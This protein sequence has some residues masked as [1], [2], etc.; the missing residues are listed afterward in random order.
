[1]KIRARIAA[2]SLVIFA[3][4]GLATV[5]HADTI[6]RGFKAKGPLQPGWV[7]ALDK[8]SANTVVAAPASDPGRI[9]GVVIDP[10][11]APVTV[12]QQGQQMY[13][14]NSGAYQTLVTLSG[15]IITP[16][17]YIS[18]SSTDGIG[19]RANQHQGFVLGQAL[20]KFDGKNG[21]ITTGADGLAIG[22][23][24]VSI[25]PGKN[26]LVKNDTAIPSFL[27]KIA[28]GVAGTEKDLT[29]ARIWAA[30]AI[31]IVSVIIAFGVLWIGIRSGMVAIGRNPLSRHSIMQ[32]LLQVIV[33]A[34]L[35]LIT[36]LVG[37]YLLL[38]L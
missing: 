1:M 24:A 11:Q 14:A 21:V 20:E 36:G 32:S 7:V 16:G 26:P 25:I 28:Q 37:V 5:T 6:V 38:K 17:D 33:I 15:G 10:S 12:R 4:V 31:F 23:V 19:A 22:R 27:R 13:V 2:V 9:Y 8:N 34:V 35:V 3:F 29:A 30:L 18:M